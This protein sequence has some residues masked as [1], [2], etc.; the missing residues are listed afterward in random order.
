[1]VCTDIHSAKALKKGSHLFCRRFMSLVWTREVF[2][3]FVDREED[4]R[5][6]TLYSLTKRRLSRVARD[7]TT[8]AEQWSLGTSL[9]RLNQSRRGKSLQIGQ[10]R[11]LCR[12]ERKSA[13]SASVPRLLSRLTT[14]AWEKDA[15]IE[16]RRTTDS[17]EVRKTVNIIRARNHAAKLKCSLTST[18][19]LRPPPDITI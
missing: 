2:A 3:A 11:T 16:G 17:L 14:R 5:D 8:S 15:D 18:A 13:R 19:L 4:V 7:I 12:M 1:M 10:E 9:R 6:E